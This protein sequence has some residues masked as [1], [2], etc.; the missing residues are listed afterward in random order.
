MWAKHKH[1]Y[2]FCFYRINSRLETLWNFWV[3]AGNNLSNYEVLKQLN[4]GNNI[5]LSLLAC[6]IVHMKN[7][8][9]NYLA[10]S[11]YF[12]NKSKGTGNEY[13]QVLPE[14]LGCF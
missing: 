4:F 3:L 12:Q 2:V 10:V 6:A 14:D 5:L 1:I 13:A 11:C 9:D 8:I 7:K